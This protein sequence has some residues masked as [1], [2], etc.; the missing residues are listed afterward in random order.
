MT[1]EQPFAE[2]TAVALA[3]SINGHADAEEWY[4]NHGQGD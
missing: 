4:D 1:N 3:D 2:A